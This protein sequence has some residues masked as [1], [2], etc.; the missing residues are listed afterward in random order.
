M[1]M[2]VILLLIS[3]QSLSIYNNKIVFVYLLPFESSYIVRIEEN[4]ILS[5]SK[6]KV[7]LSHNSHFWRDV[8]RFTTNIDT[9]G[10]LQEYNSIDIRVQLRFTNRKSNEEILSF[11]K[12]GHYQYQNKIYPK[13]TCMLRLIEKEFSEIHWSS[14]AYSK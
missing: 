6:R 11:D 13:D 9:S 8:V 7:L 3:Y 4:D 1:R 10:H 5:H 2:M 14:Y 12:F